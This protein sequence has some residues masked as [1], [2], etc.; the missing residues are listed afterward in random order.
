MESGLPYI[1]VQTHKAKSPLFLNVKVGT[2][3]Y[4]LAIIFASAYALEKFC[5]KNDSLRTF[6]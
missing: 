4:I 6:P 1:T 3:F 2:I 5:P